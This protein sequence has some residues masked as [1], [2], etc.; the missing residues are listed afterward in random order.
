MFSGCH[1]KEVTVPGWQCEIDFSSVTNLVISDGVKSIGEF[2]FF[3]CSSLMSVTIPDSITSIGD[4]AFGDCWSLKSVTIP[5]SV[6]SIGNRA[7]EGCSSLKCVTIPNSVTSVGNGAFSE[8]GELTI[9]TD[10]GNV[11]RLWIML[12]D[13]GT[14]VKEIIEQ[15]PSDQRSGGQKAKEQEAEEEESRGIRW[16]FVL[17]CV[18]V[19]GGLFFWIIRRK[20]NREGASAK[21]DSSV[22]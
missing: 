12:E 18:G 16:W 7:F 17:G 22:N 9:F 19:I 13:V 6:K 11:Y 3:R 14:N 5:K 8:C 4:R 2:A 15:M 1:L 21:T 20:N 10:K